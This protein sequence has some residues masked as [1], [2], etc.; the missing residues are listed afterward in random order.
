MD[1]KKELLIKVWKHLSFFLCLVG[2]EKKVLEKYTNNFFVI[3]LSLRAAMSQV[4]TFK[5]LLKITSD[6]NPYML[7]NRVKRMYSESF[8]YFAPV[9]GQ[10]NTSP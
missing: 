7:Q 5:I 10:T 9:S 3:N 6:F 2:V 1:M 8:S 4:L